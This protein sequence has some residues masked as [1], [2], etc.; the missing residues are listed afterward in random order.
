[1]F[2]QYIRY[3]HGNI[4]QRL[5]QIGVDFDTQEAE[6]G[7][8]PLMLALVLGH[9][10]VAMELV[11]SGAKVA[12]PVRN[13][14]TP[15]FVAAEKGLTEMVR[16]MVRSYESPIVHPITGVAMK[17]IN[18]PVVF[19]TNLRLLH[20]AAF[21]NQAQVVSLLIDMDADLNVLEDESGYTP[22][23][24]AI[25]GDNASAALDLIAA[26]AN[27]RIPSKAGRTAM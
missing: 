18:S 12:L 22:L 9:E 6:H 20:V 17:V 15:L 1:M 27:P 7:Y 25:I 19:P 14:R 16:F 8:T 13:G 11:S 26:G 5:A 10:W 4:I 21:H 23:A 24:M 2:G 3:N